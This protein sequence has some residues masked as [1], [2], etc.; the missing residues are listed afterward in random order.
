[1]ALRYAAL[2]LLITLLSLTNMKVIDL[3]NYYTEGVLHDEIYNYTMEWGTYK[4]N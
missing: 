2:T 4:P 3:D 1:M